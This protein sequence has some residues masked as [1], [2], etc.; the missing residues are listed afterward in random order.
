MLDP[1]VTRLAELLCTHSCKLGPEDRVL[2][3]A[4]DIPEEAVAEVVRVAQTTGAQVAVRLESNVVKRQLM[5]GMSEANAKTIAEIERHEME[6]MTAYIALRGSHNYAEHADIP[7]DIQSMWQREYMTPVVFGVRVPKTKWVALRWPTAGMAQQAKMS[8][9]A[10][11]KFYF[12]V[13]TLDYAKMASAAEALKALM[14]RTDQVRVVGPGETDFTLSIKG[15]GSVPCSGH[16]NIPDGEC[17]SAP[18][19]NSVN[20]VVAFNT[21]SLY[22]GTEF[23]DIRYVI[24]DGKIVEAS[25]GANT[26]KL[27][28]IL[29]T[30]EGARYFGEFA[31]GFNPYILHPMLDTLFDEKIAGSIHF[32]PGNSYDPPGG[33]G[34]KSAIHW[35]TVLIQR[36]EYG[37]GEIWFDGVLVRKDGLFVLPE[38]QA[39]NPEN[40]G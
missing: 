38:L 10:F 14:D 25:A 23:K 12:E 35:D 18:V 26:E 13:C 5:L 8:T 1:R 30:D 2:V 16:R 9:A 11:E 28:E 29:D 32:T 39:L 3:H 6:Q 24:K 27:N 31:I 33:N 15:I 36:P 22:Q 34:N 20:G 17:F 19:R 7:G 4:F 40:L 21:V 37:G